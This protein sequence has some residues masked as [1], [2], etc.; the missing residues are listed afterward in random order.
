MTRV[1]CRNALSGEEKSI[2]RA[3]Y[4]G[5]MHRGARA[6][7]VGLLL[8]LVGTTAVVAGSAVAAETTAVGNDSVTTPAVDERL[9]NVSGEQALLVGFEE[10]SVAESART[11]EDTTSVA[12]LR[13]RATVAQEPLRQFARRTPALTVEHRFWLTNAALV[14]VDT[15]RV[16]PGT[17][18][19]IEGVEWVEPN[20]RVQAH[21]SRA[22]TGNA[23]LPAASE[24]TAGSLAAAD[25]VSDSD[26]G[27]TDG[28]DQIRAPAAWEQ[29][30]TRGAGAKVAVLDSGVDTSHPDIDLAEWAEFNE[31]GGRVDSEPRDIDPRGHGTHVSATA[32]GGAASGQRIGVAPE[33]AL[34]HG[35]V[36]T[37]CSGS[38]CSGTVA[39]IVA[40]M[41]WAVAH[42]ADVLSMSLGARGYR[43]RLVEPVRNARAAGTTVVA[44]SG[45]SGPFTSG[46]PGNVYDSIAVGATDANRNV[47]SFSAGEPV[48][49]GTAWRS[50]A[51]EAWPRE[52][53]V[54][55]VTALGAAVRSAEPGDT[56]GE[57]SGTSMAVPHVSGAVALVQSATDRDLSPAAIERALVSTA[58]KPASASTPAGLRDVRYGAGIVDVPSAIAVVANTTA[59]FTLA[60]S[61]V[62][63]G[64]NVT[65]A[66]SSSTGAL[67]SHEWDLTG[68]GSVDAT[69]Q[70]VTHAFPTTGEYSVTLTVTDA[71]GE[72]DTT[73]QRVLVR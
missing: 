54:P 37:D 49:T 13:T 52:Y 40:G 70:N 64:E 34:S 26:V 17:L 69:G 56:Y 27:S 22:D 28:L 11:D 16:A 51:P 41:E 63:A 2:L 3:D 9:E 66:A 60:P 71:G 35:A 65:L 19:R 1:A 47:A 25:S 72:T 14:R 43:V 50:V 15:D 12:G 58:R 39:Q 55:T 7:L 57:K 18:A 44:S 33:A 68:D 4:A 5:C 59:A 21:A 42:D 31:T 48:D 29:Y 67:A 45:N 38:S 6:V 24:P 8:G 53:V 62:S 61:T 32:T 20:A 36:L 23:S 73:T 46:S 10:S 30:D